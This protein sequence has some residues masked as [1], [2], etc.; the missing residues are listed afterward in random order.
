MGH[1]L[2]TTASCSLDYRSYSLRATGGTDRTI[3]GVAI[4]YES[5]QRVA[6][7]DTRAI[8]GSS[9]LREKIASGAVRIEDLPVNVRALVNHRE[10]QYL[11]GSKSGALSLE[12]KDNALAFELTLPRTRLADDVLGLMESEQQLPV[13]IGFLSRGRRSNVK[14][15]DFDDEAL[16][17]AIETPN[18]GSE[19]VTPLDNTEINLQAGKLQGS[20]FVE[21]RNVKTGRSWRV[22]K[23][24]DLREISI[25]YGLAPA[26][27]GVYARQDE[28]GD[29]EERS[30]AYAELELLCLGG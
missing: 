4:K 14:V 11:G 2:G 27:E 28:L 7:R 30:R 21:G 25:L 8:A 22:Y 3:R 18:R 13:S 10:E 16:E 24:L 23:S 6:D 5:W 1:S 26:W 19:K 29:S 15:I 20:D 17:K 12:N 9:R